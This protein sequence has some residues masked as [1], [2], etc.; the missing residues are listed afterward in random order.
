[1][2]VRVRVRAQERERAS[3]LGAWV[4]PRKYDKLY[5]SMTSWGYSMGLLGTRTFWAYKR[6]KEMLS[7]WKVFRLAAAQWPL[8]IS[9]VAWQTRSSSC[10]LR[11][12]ILAYV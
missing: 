6:A 10:S 8:Q 11:D 2:C 1:M 7:A 9:N 4:N 3:N 5:A 12:H